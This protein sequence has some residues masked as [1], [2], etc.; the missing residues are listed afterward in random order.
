MK[1]VGGPILSSLTATHY[2][3]P[4]KSAIEAYTSLFQHQLVTDVILLASVRDACSNTV[5]ARAF[6][7]SDRERRVAIFSDDIDS[8]IAHPHG[9]TPEARALFSALHLADHLRQSNDAVRITL[10]TATPD[11]AEYVSVASPGPVAV[12]TVPD[13]VESQEETTREALRPLV[14]STNDKDGRWTYEPHLDEQN[15]L[16]LVES[17]ELGRGVLRVARTTPYFGTVSTALHEQPILIVSKRAMNRAMNGDKVAVQLLPETEWR[18]PKPSIDDNSESTM[19]T[20]QPVGKVVAILDPARRMFCGSVDPETISGNWAQFQPVAPNVPRHRFFSKVMSSLVGKRIVVSTIRWAAEHAM[21]DGHYSYTVGANVTKQA[22]PTRSDRAGEIGDTWTESEVV[23]IEHGIRH[24]AL[25]TPDIAACLPPEGYYGDHEGNN[26]TA[27]FEAERAQPYRVDLSSRPIAS[28]DPPGCVD[29]DDALHAAPLSDLVASG[30]WLPWDEATM[31]KDDGSFVE[32]G[33]HIADV[34]HFVHPGTAVDAEAAL[35][36]TSVYFVEKRI[37]MLPSLLTTDVCSLHGAWRDDIQGY[38]GGIETEGLSRL[39]F[40]ALFL[41]DINTG[42]QVAEPVFS[43]SVI[44]SKAE[45]SY[46]TA[47]KMLDGELVDGKPVGPPGAAVRTSLDMLWKLA[48]KLRDFRAQAGALSL[49]SDAVKFEFSEELDRGTKKPVG[50]HEYPAVNTHS[51]VE[52]FMLLANGAVAQK[53][54]MTLPGTALLRLHPPPKTTALDELNKL[55]DTKYGVVLN[56]ETNLQLANSLRV[57]ETKLRKT[58]APGD[59]GRAMK[60][61]KIL[62][63]RCM[64]LAVYFS[65]GA[66]GAGLSRALEAAS[67]DTTPP[68]EFAHFGLAAP[69]YTHFTS[70]IRRYADLI[71]HR[72]LASSIGVMDQASLPPDHRESM[73]LQTLADRMNERKKHADDAG[74]DNSANTIALMFRNNKD[75]AGKPVAACVLSVRPDGLVVMMP[76]YGVEGKVPTKGTYDS[77]RQS[78]TVNGRE[79]SVFDTVTVVPQCEKTQ[80][81]QLRLNITLA[82]DGKRKA[83]TTAGVKK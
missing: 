43:K 30:A 46:G 39:A 76:D 15:A 28:V 17:G 37:D 11:A 69:I 68:P 83:A 16:G 81:Y 65:S 18:A 9:A 51:L 1:D 67:F 40:S 20:S 56:G 26:P 47:Q 52:E 13:W 48:Q 49:A 27:M 58:M 24:H 73:K 41:F 44:A 36:C 29:I 62:V 10:L 59:A 72:L 70:P 60:H 77:R 4:D 42:R 2:V 25:T 21:P 75:M 6:K 34:S 80:S 64:S 32:V 5:K 63:T 22:D 82:Q 7:D 3:I 8:S 53:V 50:V 79:I 57:I 74:R 31:A 33:V 78:L 19:P 71:V 45:L 38:P 14:E 23:L 12:G 61:I 35:R 54:W 55:L 66:L